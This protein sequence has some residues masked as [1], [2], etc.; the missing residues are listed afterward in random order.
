MIVPKP[1]ESAYY[2]A[3]YWNPVEGE[4]FWKSLWYSV[5][6]NKWIGPWLWACDRYELIDKEGNP[7]HTSIP[8]GLL[9]KQYIPHTKGKDYGESLYKAI[10]L[11]KN[12]GDMAE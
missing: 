7:F 10:E 3:F 12:N 8:K 9:V 2:Y 5:E 11:Y 1:N 4:W 6:A